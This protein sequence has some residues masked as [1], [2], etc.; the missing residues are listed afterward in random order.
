MIAIIDYGAGNL[1]SVNKALEKLGHENVITDN[2]TIIENASGII[3]P[4]VGTF[5]ALMSN[6]KSKGLIDPLMDSIKNSK[7]YLGICIGMQI[8]FEKGHENGMHKGL[9]IFPGEVIKFHGLPHDH[10]IPHMGWNN[11]KFEQYNNA[12]FEDIEDNSKFYFVHSYHVDT[13]QNEVI[14]ATTEYG[15]KFTS[16]VH[17]DNIYGT[18]FHP[19][20]SGKIGLQLLD[21]FAKLCEQGE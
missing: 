8:L 19:E 7:P 1:R 17:K 4:G 5:G 2:P 21:N 14:A 10:K 3:L 15:Y 12:L 11:V 18:Q 13:N 20:K 6:M 9:G 16:G